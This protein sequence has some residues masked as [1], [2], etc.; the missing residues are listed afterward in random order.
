MTPPIRLSTPSSSAAIAPMGAE[1]RSWKVD[2][3]ELLWSADPAFWPQ[4][5]PILFPVVGWTRNGEMRI[6]GKPCPLGLPGFAAR[7]EFE[8]I[9]HSA[10]EASF[11]L[12]DDEMTRALYPFAFELE[13]KYSLSETSFAAGFQVRNPG[14]EPLPY[15]LGLH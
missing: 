15:A 2:G 10:A 5:S 4:V 8:L 13:V 11:R 9:G 12:V 1:P 3:S 6:K 14:P 7:H